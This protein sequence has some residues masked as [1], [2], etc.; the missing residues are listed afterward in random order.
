MRRFAELYAAL[1][2]TT[3]TNAKVAALQAYF[4]TAPHAD[5]AWALYFLSGRRLKRLLPGRVLW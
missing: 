5:A 1:D 3:S 2:R 4:G